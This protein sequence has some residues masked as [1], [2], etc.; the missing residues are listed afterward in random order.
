MNKPRALLIT[1]FSAIPISSGGGKRTYHTIKYLSSN[2]DLEVWAFINNIDKSTKEK[3]WLESLGV[4]YKYFELNANNLFSFV[5]HF[6]PYWFS[7][8]LNTKI[9][10]SLDS[11]N[12]D[13]DLIQIE[14][15]QLLYLGN[16][17]KKNWKKSIFVA[18]DVSTVSFWRRLAGEKNPLKIFLHFCRLI[19]I[20]LFEMFFI[21]KFSEVWSMSNIDADIL[22]KKFAA[23]KVK[24]VP[25]GIEKVNFL[26]KSENKKVITFG[27]IG[28]FA[29]S[30]NLEAVSYILKVVLP[31]LE[32][33][34]LSYQLFL[35][36]DQ[37]THLIK[38]MANDANLPTSKITVMGHLENVE[39]FYE[40]IDFLLAPIF[41]GSGTRIKILESLSFG[42]PVVTTTIGAEGIEIKSNF[43]SIIKNDEAKNVKSWLAAINK[44]I[45]NNHL[46]SDKSDLEKT[47]KEMNWGKIF[48]KYI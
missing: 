28:G 18:Y 7:P 17:L 27:Y 45:K 47:L 21:R 43:L 15:T 9:C 39:S 26:S 42:K 13:L 16:K 37:D 40:K 1:P 22:R 3:A 34:Q 10:E 32:K 4:K 48:S 35:A 33:E 30:P 6:Q 29:H 23:K 5:L 20:C 14:G 31:A 11:L 38:K 41:S 44:L 2:Y 19:E 24:V 36:G 8:W 12:A 46:K 25:N